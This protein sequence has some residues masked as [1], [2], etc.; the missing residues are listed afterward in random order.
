MSFRNVEGVGGEIV[1]KVE[2]EIK[3]GNSSLRFIST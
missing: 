2:E 3:T 1:L